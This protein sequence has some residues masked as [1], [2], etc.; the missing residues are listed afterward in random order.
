[1]LYGMTNH[2][3]V[4]QLCHGDRAAFEG[5]A[6]APGGASEYRARHG[7]PRRITLEL[8]AEIVRRTLEHEPPVG[9]HW[10]TRLI[11]AEM[12]VHQTTISRIWFAHGL[13]PHR[14][15]TSNCHRSPVR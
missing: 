4:I 1:M 7:R 12:G 2:I 3:R 5:G 9:T 6:V 15:S 11:A 10:S 13:Q 8:E 14:W